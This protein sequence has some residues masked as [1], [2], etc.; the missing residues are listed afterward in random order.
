MIRFF[1]AGM[2]FGLLFSH[3]RES[4]TEC[5][6]VQI[7]PKGVKDSS[8]GK[9]YS[10]FSTGYSLLH[11]SD[12]KRYVKEIGRKISLTRAIEALPKEERAEIWRIYFGRVR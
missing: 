3:N 1:K 2:E 6:L 4:G 5:A 10:I 8:T 11:E 7:L 12:K 9:G